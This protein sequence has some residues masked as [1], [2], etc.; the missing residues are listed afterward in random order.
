MT[1]L[2][3]RLGWWLG[4]PM[5]KDTPGRRDAAYRWRSPK[6][7]IWHLFRELLGRTNETNDWLHLSDGG[8][9][10]N[11]GVYEMIMRRCRYIVACDASADPARS[12]DDFGRTIRNVR[13]DLGVAV[14]YAGS[15]W[16]IEADAL[17]PNG[18]HALLDIHYPNGAV[19][20]LLYIKPALYLRDRALPRDVWQYANASGSFP[21]E[22]T[23]D[24]FFSESQFES[25][26][27]LGE[28]QLHQ[29]ILPIAR[30]EELG[31]AD[32][33]RVF[34]V[35]RASVPSRAEAMAG[36]RTGAAEEKVA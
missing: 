2:N 3:V 8:H 22:S 28:Y 9:F 30:N 21:H 32:W 27:A 6:F 25:Y 10:D 20:R 11:L 29:G 4:N 16:T 14:T 18:G 35:A 17:V 34:D 5:T 36:L 7:G 15:D 24:Q 33:E 23:L 12:I 1:F 13:A 31:K 26:R 19:G